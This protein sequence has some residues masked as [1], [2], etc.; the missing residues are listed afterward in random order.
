MADFLHYP[1]SQQSL[2]D[3]GNTIC[4]TTMDDEVKK[5]LYSSNPHIQQPSAK[6]AGCSPIILPG[7]SNGRYSIPQCTPQ[8][9]KRLETLSY[10][11]GGAGTLAL[12][13]LVDELNISSFIGDLNTFGGNGIGVAAQASKLM[14]SDIAHYDKL[15]KEYDG[16]RNHR[17]APSTLVRKEAEL[18]QAF[19]KMNDSLNQKGQHILHKHKSKT[20]QVLSATGRVGYESIPIGSNADVQ[21][22]AKLAKF[23]R[24]AGPGFIALDGYL[25]YDKVASMRQ[26][27]N[28]KWKREAVIQTTGFAAGLLAGAAIVFFIGFAP[29]GLILGLVAAGAAAILADR[30]STSIIST[31]YDLMAN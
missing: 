6:R 12:A 26:Q 15:L 24:V 13:E 8:E 17:A 19:K 7:D 4:K 3:V 30:V 20:K 5:I 31:G 28:P 11:V 10:Q 9:H 21:R 2:E 23:G 25:R 29:A 22:L 27:N 16:L 18:K 1:K 14:V